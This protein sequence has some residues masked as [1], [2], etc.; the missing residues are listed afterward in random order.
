MK[1]K[2]A[3]EPSQRGDGFSE[4]W[5]LCFPTQYKADPTLRAREG[6]DGRFKRFA[7]LTALEIA[8]RK[9]HEEI[10]ELL[11]HAMQRDQSVPE[12]LKGQNHGSPEEAG[13]DRGLEKLF[14]AVE[15][16]RLAEVVE[17]LEQ[18]F[19]VNGR[20]SNGL[21]ATMRAARYG[22]EEVLCELIRRG[23]DLEAREAVPC[24]IAAVRNRSA[25]TA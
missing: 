15:A 1:A 3:V 5:I 25:A 24:R 9:N 23:A 10:V 19:P 17:L 13:M 20:N 12:E 14:T 7:G 4:G 11:Q 2:L 21:T 18:G 22:R 16:G 6:T 8:T